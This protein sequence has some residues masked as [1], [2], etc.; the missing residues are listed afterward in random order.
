[1]ISAS[2]DGHLFHST[3]HLPSPIVLVL[4][5]L[6]YALNT[7]STYFHLP[8]DEDE[9]KDIENYERKYLTWVAEPSASENLP[10][11]SSGQSQ[12]HSDTSS[13]TDQPETLKTVLSTNCLYEILGVPKYSSLDK[14]TL[15]RAYLARSRACHP[16]KFP[17]N[18]DATHAFQKV[19]VAYE[20]L[21]KP[22][23]KRVYDTHS[24]DSEYDVF[25]IHPSSHAEET[26]KEVVL[27]VFNDFLDGDLEIIRT[28]LKALN[29]INPSI[30]LEEDG[31][32]SVLITL[33]AIRERALTCRTCINALHAELARLLEVQHAFKEL[34]YF[35]IFGRTRITI[36]L[37]RITLGL[38]IVLEQALSGQVFARETVRENEK[39]L[40]PRHVT[41]LIK[42]VDAALEKMERMLK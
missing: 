11:T 4:S 26:F 15:R 39:Q 18:P 42:G 19:A 1:M 28:L 36:Q 17:D 22:S 31:I 34:S 29:E 30:R 25:A 9:D 41:R 38:P 37:T 3:P 40:F 13:E 14:I 33:E 23:H 5:M 20:V 2:V 35:D 7:A 24:T 32:N 12:P 8:I 27:S 21:S 10:S 16:D 6:S